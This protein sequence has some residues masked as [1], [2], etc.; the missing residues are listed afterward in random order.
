MAMLCKNGCVGG[1]IL[2][3]LVLV[4]SCASRGASSDSDEQSLN[5]QAAK[6]DSELALSGQTGR[7]LRL[8]VRG[9][10][11]GESQASE[12]RVCAYALGGLDAAPKPTQVQGQGPQL[13]CTS[14]RDAD[15]VATIELKDVP[16]PCYVSVFHDEN[17]NGILDFASFN[18]VLAKK[19]GPAEGVGTLVFDD[20]EPWPFS[21]PVWVEQGWQNRDVTMHYADLPFTGLVKETAWKALFALY[22]SW[23]KDLNNPDNSK[24]PTNQIIG[25][26]RD[27]Q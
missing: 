19:E 6:G 20:K 18:I 13:V 26:I 21:R 24:S 4:T 25:P 5:R 9:L 14:V 7:H 15:G 2:A 3:S 11:E 10:S 1:V 16:Y 8:K 27:Q 23:A 12:H 22:V 17:L